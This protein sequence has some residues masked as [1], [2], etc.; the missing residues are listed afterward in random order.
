MHQRGKILKTRT[1][2]T[3]IKLTYGLIFDY[4]KFQNFLI[5]LRKN[6]NIFKS[7]A[8]GCLLYELATLQILPK[9]EWFEC[10]DENS[11]S[12]KLNELCNK[13]CERTILRDFIQK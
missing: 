11:F 6:N 10:D 8:L 2:F 9:S 1:K 3:R 4:F 12:S 5:L 7:R 13:Y